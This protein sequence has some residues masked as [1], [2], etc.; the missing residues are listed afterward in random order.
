MARSITL[1]QSNVSMINSFHK[2]KAS[3]D[4]HTSGLILNNKTEVSG[5]VNQ[6]LLASFKDAELHNIFTSEFLITTE[7]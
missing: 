1:G 3:Q 7:N 4:V 2:I 6:K 5:C